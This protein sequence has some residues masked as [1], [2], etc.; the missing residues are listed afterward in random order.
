MSKSS[1][2]EALTPSE[3]PREEVLGE[4]LVLSGEIKEKTWKKQ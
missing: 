3:F 4:S 1:F 2:R